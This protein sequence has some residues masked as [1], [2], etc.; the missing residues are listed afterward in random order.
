MDVTERFYDI[1]DCSEIFMPAW[2]ASLL[3]EG[4]RKRARKFVMAPSEV[5]TILILFHSSHYRDFKNSYLG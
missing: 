1:D 2:L 5:M 4:K 3:P